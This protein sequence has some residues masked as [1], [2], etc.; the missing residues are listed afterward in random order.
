[1]LRNLSN[2]SATHP[3]TVAGGASG[4]SSPTIP[5]PPFTKSKNT[6][7]SLAHRN[8]IFNASILE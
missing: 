3:D 2:N 4:K 8:H 1:M 7:I 5:H 6:N